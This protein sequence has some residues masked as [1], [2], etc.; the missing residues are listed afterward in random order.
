[1][2]YHLLAEVKL[3]A[4]HKFLFHMELST[5]Y[6][7]V[8][9][10]SI[11][12]TKLNLYSSFE[13]QEKKKY[14]PK[15]F[16][17]ET[18]SKQHNGK[19][20][21]HAK[22][23]IKKAIDYL[24]FLSREKE[25]PDTYHGANYKFRLAFITLTLPSLQV[26]SD[27]EIKERCL[28]QLLI[29]LKKKHN[30]RNYLWRAEKQNN[31]NLHFHI[32]V[33]KFIPW[34]ELRDMWNRIINKLGY[35]DTYRES[36]RNF[37]KNGFKVRTDLL[38]SWSETKQLQSYN[39]NK[40]SDW[41]SPNSTDIHAVHK[42]KNIQAYVAKYCTKDEQSK[43]LKGRLWGCNEQLSNIPGAQIVVDNEINEALCELFD[44][45]SPNVYNGDY[46][47]SISIEFAMLSGLESKVLFE[48]FA[49]FLSQHFGTNY[50]TQFYCS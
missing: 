26:H 31:G 24:L 42:V 36:M 3:Y 34:S 44:K 14:Y 17:I 25:L 7:I 15:R 28:N 39:R 32:L 29:E 48:A 22:R 23:K 33:D 20:S 37:H 35:V 30:V 6:E 18:A 8:P 45:Y 9:M 49:G 16:K 10:L 1:M 40:Q 47:S 27:N 5:P 19:V 2:V 11:H 13:W 41:A 50:Q 4:Y 21:E 38:E 43:G 46:F 12:P